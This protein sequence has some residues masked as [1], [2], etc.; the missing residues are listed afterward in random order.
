MRCVEWLVAF[1]LIAS[2]AACEVPSELPEQAAPP[3]A[4][5][6]VRVAIFNIWQL[7]TAKLTDTD[8]AGA[9]LD[10]QARAAATIVQRVR[11]DVLVINEI[12]HDYD[13]PDAGLELNAE[14]FARA[15]LATGESPI[16][17]P[18]AWAAANNTGILSGADLNADAYVATAAD[19][20]SRA[21]GDDSYGYGEYPGQYSMAVLSRHP[22]DTAG[23]RSFRELLWRDLPGHHI[24]E[25]F[26]PPETLEVLRL[27][28]KSHQDV[29]ISVDG[30]R[31]HL[32]MS[33]PTP[34]VFDGDEDRNGRRNFDEIRLWALY[35]NG[36]GGLVD[37]Q[38]TAGGIEPGA[39][40]VILGDLNARPD[41]LDSNYDGM[42]PIAQLLGH[43]RVTD[44][45]RWAISAG[46][47]ADAPEATTEFGGRGARID[48]VLPSSELVVLDGGVYW[49]DAQ[50]DGEGNDL[51]KRASDHRLVW[52]D[53]TWR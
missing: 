10:E 38:G 4:L 33:H 32:L 7:S 15:Y 11:P 53:L 29:P 2:L 3:A 1:A 28:S 17:Y 19:V 23:V 35:L 30:H 36:D 51:A 5:P 9:G 21:H 48:Y 41:E 6:T 8:E 40:F 14:R 39:S 52:M 34:P 45:A 26:Y 18:Y 13:T 22:V 47:P 24:P 42:P 20:G 44:T 43:P 37:D 49:P 12:D 46:A 50:L 16:E 25:D 31:L 27:S